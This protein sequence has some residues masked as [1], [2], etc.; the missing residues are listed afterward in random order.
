MTSDSVT[1][2]NCWH[3]NTLHDSFYSL[4][5]TCSKI[6]FKSQYVV[7]LMPLLQKYFYMIHYPLKP[8]IDINLLVPNQ[9][10]TNMVIVALTNVIHK[11]IFVS[12]GHATWEIVSIPVIHFQRPYI[13]S[14]L[15]P[16]LSPYITFESNI[17]ALWSPYITFESN[18]WSQYI[19][20]KIYMGSK[21]NPACAK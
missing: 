1:T 7:T 10:Q 3:D 9:S 21:L 12:L 13:T 17:W 19:T 20:S 18:L 14:D 16:F 5:N 8:C 2:L 11:C 6:I 15:G 4:W